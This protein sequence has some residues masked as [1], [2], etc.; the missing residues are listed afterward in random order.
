MCLVAA[1]PGRRGG[2]QAHKVKQTAAPMFSTCRRYDNPVMANEYTLTSDAC[3]HCWSVLITVVDLVKDDSTQ[4]AVYVLEEEQAE[5]I[6]KALRQ[7][8]T[9]TAAPVEEYEPLVGLADGDC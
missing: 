5:A 8:P 7:A 6:L 9:A 1:V 3:T 2:D 4:P